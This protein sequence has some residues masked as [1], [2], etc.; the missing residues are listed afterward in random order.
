MSNFDTADH[1]RKLATVS[2]EAGSFVIEPCLTRGCQKLVVGDCVAC[3]ACFALEPL[4]L[5]GF[6]V[7]A[8]SSGT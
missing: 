1:G 6:R 3:A 2:Q 8:E 5:Q 7:R 4:R